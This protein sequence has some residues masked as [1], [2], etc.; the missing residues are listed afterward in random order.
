MVAATSISLAVIPVMVRFA[1]VLGMMDK[2]NRRKVHQIPVPR[3]GGWGIVLGA[4]LPLIIM[5]PNEKVFHAYIWGALVLIIF[6]V[7]DDR[8]EIGHYTKF[9]GQLMAVIPM[10]IYA[11][12]YVSSLPFLG[13][14]DLPSGIAMAFTVF[15]LIGVINALNHSDGLDGLAAGESLLSLGAITFLLYHSGAYFAMLIAVA[16]I[17]GVLGFLRYNTY[18]AIVFMGDGGSQYLGFTLGFLTVFLIQEIDTALSPTVALLLLGLP[19]VDI[20]VVLKKRIFQGKNWFRASRNHVHHRLLELGFVHQESVVIIYTVQILFITAAMLLR[21][22]SDWLILL[23]FALICTILYLPLN[24]SEKTGWKIFRV[25]DQ[26]AFVQAISFARHKFLVVLPRRFLDVTIPAY[27]IIGSVIAI[28]VP[29]DFSMASAV[30]FFL[31]LLEPV[32][33]KTTRSIVRRTFI[34]LIAAFVIYL[35]FDYP[36]AIIPWTAPLRYGFFFLI[37]LSVAAAVRFSPRRRRFEFQTTAMDYL[38]VFM[39]LAASGYLTFQQAEN[40]IGLFVIKI[41]VILYACE[42]SIIEKRERWTP[43]SISSL[44]AAAILAVRGVVFN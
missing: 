28:E 31:L 15:A 13:L 18:P 1:P 36:L 32:F 29:R 34:Y 5:L 24:L 38:M 16:T 20:L 35:H 2:P 23:S 30:I 37:A 4:L 39:V 33:N 41:I 21:Y 6:G 40:W 22:E 11:D 42:L 43:L 12:L 26:W 10:V 8:R 7:W 44:L 9:F 27:L 25:K 17:G 3:V 19:I 14:H